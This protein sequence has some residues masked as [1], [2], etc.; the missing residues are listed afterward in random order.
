MSG[1]DGRWQ[2]KDRFRCEIDAD[3]DAGRMLKLV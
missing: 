2:I 3:P 1:S